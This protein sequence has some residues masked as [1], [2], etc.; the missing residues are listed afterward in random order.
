MEKKEH[1][2]QMFCMK[3]LLQANNG[4]YVVNAYMYPLI[5]SNAP[6]KRLM[7]ETGI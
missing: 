3:D 2:T 1:P 7:T 6:S 4:L 5:H